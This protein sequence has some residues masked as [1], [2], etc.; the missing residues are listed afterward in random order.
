MIF[1]LQSLIFK[2]ADNFIS[3]RCIGGLKIFSTFRNA[4]TKLENFL[5]LRK[6]IL[7]LFRPQQLIFRSFAN[8]VYHLSSRPSFAH[9]LECHIQDPSYSLILIKI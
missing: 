9:Q 8:D 6:I 7:G 2:R 4:D 1:Y 3:Y 5:E